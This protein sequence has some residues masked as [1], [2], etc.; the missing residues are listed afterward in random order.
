[1]QLSDAPRKPGRRGRGDRHA[2]IARLPVALVDRIDEEAVQRGGATRVDVVWHVLAQHF[3]M[4]EIDP[5]AVEQDADQQ[6]LDISHTS[7]A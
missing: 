7:A 5:L 1:M 4:P 3:G 6:T 2:V